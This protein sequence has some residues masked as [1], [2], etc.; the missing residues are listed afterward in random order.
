MY[1]YI[2]TY[3][4]TYACIN[5][6]IYACI[7]LYI[8]MYQFM[9]SIIYICKNI[10]GTYRYMYTY[11]CI[12]LYICIYQLIHMHISIYGFLYISDINDSNDTEWEEEIIIIFLL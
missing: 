10:I 4:S 11:A 3:I 9:D 1:R 6:H 5:I 12:K 2:Y 7:N 8:C